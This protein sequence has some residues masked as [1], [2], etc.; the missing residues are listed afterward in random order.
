MVK[1]ID[2][3]RCIAEDGTPYTVIECGRVIRTSTLSGPKQEHIT[4]IDYRLS[5]GEP[6]NKINAVT[7]QIFQTDV[8][9]R[10][11]T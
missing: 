4:T 10:K 2:R 3:F 1:E 6:V 9:I 7:F 8:V 5:T 11:I